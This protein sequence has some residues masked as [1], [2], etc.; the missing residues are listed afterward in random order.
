MNRYSHLT[1]PKNTKVRLTVMFVPF[2]DLIII[3]AFIALGLQVSKAFNLQAIMQ[4]VMLGF[5]ALAGILAV[6][7]TPLAPQI[8]NWKVLY[9]I[10]KQDRNRYYPIFVKGTNNGKRSK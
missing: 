9:S 5:S 7:K 1:M 3:I 4:F 2:I 10:F 6:A 8:S